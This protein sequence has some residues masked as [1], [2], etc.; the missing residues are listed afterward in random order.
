MT[1]LRVERHGVVGRIILAR[2]E[3]RNALDRQIVEELFSSL[4]RLESAK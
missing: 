1:G 2:I 4:Q 3:K